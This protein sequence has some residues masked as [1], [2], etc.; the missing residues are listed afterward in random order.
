[1]NIVNIGLVFENCEY[2][3]IPIEY[4]SSF[5]L[6]GVSDSISYYT[7]QN[8]FNKSKSANSLYIMFTENFYQYKGCTQLDTAVV[9]RIKKFADICHFELNFEDALPESYGIIWKDGSSDYENLGQT[10]DEE[11][12]VLFLEIKS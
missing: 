12:G 10:F 8:L 9:D 5:H 11:D 3:I 6:G 1:M 7:R 4:I 2:C